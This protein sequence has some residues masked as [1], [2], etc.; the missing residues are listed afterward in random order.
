MTTTRSLLRDAVTAGWISRNLQRLR[1]AR[2]MRSSLRACFF[3]SL[4]LSDGRIS[5]PLRRALRIDALSRESEFRWQTTRV[6]PGGFA[7]RLDA[8]ER[9]FG[10]FPPVAGLTE[11]SGAGSGQ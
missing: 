4:R 11:R 7:L 3:V 9:A 10:T 8:S 2:L 6:R 5:Y 1:S